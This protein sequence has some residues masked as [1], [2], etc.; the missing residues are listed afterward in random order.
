YVQVHGDPVPLLDTL[1]S[2]GYTLTNRY[3]KLDSLD[4]IRLF[5][6]ANC[7]CPTN[8]KPYKMKDNIP[9]GGC[10][11][12]STL[13]A[14][15]MLAQRSCNRHFNGSLAV[16]QSQDKADFLLNSDAIFLNKA[17]RTRNLNN[18]DFKAWA[19]GYP[20]SEQGDCVK[21]QRCDTCQGKVAW[22]NERCGR[23][24]VYACQTTACSTD[25]YCPHLR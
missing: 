20:D 23:D 3:S 18:G 17:Q 5:C 4:L 12:I 2:P 11:K 16:V 24:L 25:H 22:F 6:K 9:Y 21:M 8:Y 7:F 10:Y 15:Q 14:I 1:A 13:P 19:F